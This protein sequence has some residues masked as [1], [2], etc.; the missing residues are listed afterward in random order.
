MEVWFFLVELGWNTGFV[1]F[2][3]EGTFGDFLY[4]Y[5]GILQEFYVRIWSM[6]LFC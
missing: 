3:L 5:G 2:S 4:T 1:L 6:I